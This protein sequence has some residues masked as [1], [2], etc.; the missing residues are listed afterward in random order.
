MDQK[1]KGKKSNKNFVF[2]K[3]VNLEMLI[4]TWDQDF[5]NKTNIGIFY[6]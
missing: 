3:L 6:H 2:S 1:L 4:C 5:E